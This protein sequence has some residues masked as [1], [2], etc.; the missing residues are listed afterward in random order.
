MEYKEVVVAKA[1]ELS[2]G[3]M[4]QVAVEGEEILLTSVGGE[5]SALGAFCAHYNAR[6][7]T[8]VLSG[9]TIVCPWHQACYCAKSGDLKEPPALNALTKFETFVRGDDIVLKI[10]EKISKT[11][12]PDMIAA[13]PARDPRTFVN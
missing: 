6:L 12:V 13:D 3:T 10:P 9:D 1:S 5:I 2:D 4:K 7:E 11:R 8:G